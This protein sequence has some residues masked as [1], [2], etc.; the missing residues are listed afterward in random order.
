MRL[1]Y[2]WRATLIV[3]IGLFMAVLDNTVVNVA[4]PQIKDY[5]HIA[6]YNDVVWVATAYFL[7]QAAIIPAVGYVSDRIGT[8]LVFLVALALFTL[9]SGLCALAP[10]LPMLIIFRVFQGIGGGALFPIVF[11]ITFRIFP[12]NER[13]IASATVGVPVLLAP[14]FGPTIGGYL[15]TTFSWHEIFTI[16]LPIG[17]LAFIAAAMILRGRAAERA[18][19]GGVTPAQR[20]SFDLLGL[21]LVISGVTT[22]VY[23]ISEAGTRGWTDQTVI[24]FMSVGAALL[25]AF[26]LVELFVARD[27]VIDLRLFGTYS[28]TVGN[29][30]LGAMGA[31]FFGG[32]ILFPIFFQTV[33]NYS[34]LNSGEIF[35][36]QGST[37]TLGV[38][39]S[40]R[41][42]NRVG[43]RPLAFIGLT[44]V[45][46]T[47]IRLTQFDL[48]T[49][50]W[51][52]QGWMIL[53]GLGF[54]LTNTPLQ[55]FTLSRVNNRAMARASSLLNVL[56]QIFAAIGVAVLTTYLAQTT[57]SHAQSLND[58]IQQ[59]LTANP[60]TGAAAACLAQVGAQGQAVVQA[61]LG[62]YISQHAL[63]SGVDDTF[64]VVLIGL[65]SAAFLALFMGRD[66]N[67]QDLKLKQCEVQRNP[68]PQTDAEERPAFAVVE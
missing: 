19:L 35:I 54:G 33:L 67:V 10:N 58:Q 64:V 47:T 50:G 6:N 38:L 5:F 3:A 4:L 32:V 20:Q 23:G 45:A 30:L 21:V 36:L 16:N 46:V 66:R 24:S 8:K 56:R 40:G 60:P 31:F 57:T 51:S 22:L 42:Y 49:T 41:L 43:P 12:P 39:L 48:N 27:P 68:E 61:C 44:L 26:A 25:V 37:A 11:A 15:T 14:A 55:T 1:E 53:R 7:A 28:F 9:G 52:I 62:Q 29:L 17:V 63:V 13:S 65:A 18:A 2:K 59:G 34:P